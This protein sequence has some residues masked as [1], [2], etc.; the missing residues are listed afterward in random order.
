[1]RNVKK[2]SFLQIGIWGFVLEGSIATPSQWRDEGRLMIIQT[3][4]VHCRM[5][6]EETLGHRYW[7]CPCWSRTRVKHKLGDFNEALWPRCLTRS[8]VVPVNCNISAK[9]VCNIQKMMIEI[10]CAVADSPVA[11][12]QE[13]LVQKKTASQRVQRYFHQALSQEAAGASNHQ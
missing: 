8:G 7:K 13:S 5:Q 9:E 10:S 3:V 4:C 2:R 11:Q 12:K 6:V 1:M